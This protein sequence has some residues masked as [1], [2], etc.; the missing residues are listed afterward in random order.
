MSTMPAMREATLPRGRVAEHPVWSRALGTTELAPRTIL[1]VIVSSAVEDREKVDVPPWLERV[2]L[3]HAGR[4]ARAPAS[5][6]P[7][8]L[9]ACGA[10]PS[11]PRPPRSPARPRPRRPP[12]A[13]G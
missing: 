1:P 8:R 4:E 13:P 2:S 7:P 10:S 5:A 3:T 9:A 12:P 11:Q 6:R